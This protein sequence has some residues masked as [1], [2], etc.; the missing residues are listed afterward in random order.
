MSDLPTA[1][2]SERDDEA[3]NEK[4]PEGAYSYVEVHSFGLNTSIIA[5][6]LKDYA[7]KLVANAHSEMSEEQWDDWLNEHTEA[8]T[9]AIDAY[10]DRKLDA[11]VEGL[12]VKKHLDP[13]TDKHPWIDAWN[14][15]RQHH[16]N[17]I[18]VA[19]QSIL[20]QKSGF[21]VNHKSFNVN[22]NVK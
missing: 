7:L 14:R 1:A 12:P 8:Y 19:K 10:L 16:N 5:D 17:I 15:V 3:E 2:D 22:K 4:T 20:S 13:N 18:D 6:T 9:E 21:N 11:A